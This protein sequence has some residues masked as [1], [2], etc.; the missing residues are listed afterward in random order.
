MSF[1][2][3]KE[4]Q[5]HYFDNLITNEG[6]RIYVDPEIYQSYQKALATG[7]TEGDARTGALL[8]QALS[9]AERAATSVKELFGKHQAAQFDR[10]MEV[11]DETRD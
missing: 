11:V 9:L 1:A 3:D 2:F 7:E 10:A 6:E 5:L 4:K 8:L